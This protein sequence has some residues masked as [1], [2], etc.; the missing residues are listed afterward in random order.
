M[1]VGCLLG[2][3]IEGDVT[4]CLWG[5]R[6]GRDRRRALSRKRNPFCLGGGGGLGLFGGEC[7]CVCGG[8]GGLPFSSL[9]SGSCARAARARF[10]RS[11]K[12]DGGGCEIRLGGG[13]VNRN[14]NFACLRSWAL[15]LL[16]RPLSITLLNP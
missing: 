2:G 14:A 9:F 6:G 13:G 12:D 7:V 1:Y 4:F 16:T 3:W 5:W 11:P 15:T 8:E 10:K